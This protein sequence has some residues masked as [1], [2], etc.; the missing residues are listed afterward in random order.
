MSFPS[1]KESV[2]FESF[3]DTLRNL[4]I[5]VKKYVVADADSGVELSRNELC[6]A[7][8]D[9]IEV[10][11]DSSWWLGILE[12]STTFALSGKVGYFP[13]AVIEL[14]DKFNQ[15]E[16]KTESKLLPSNASERAII[17]A[18]SPLQVECTDLNKFLVH[19]NKAFTSQVSKS[20]FLRIDL[21]RFVCTQLGC[22]I[23]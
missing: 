1:F 13:A 4:E 7:Q 11:K 16:K 8:G 6:F 10:I 20:L 18:E 12:T 3:L 23:G 5:G 22:R 17:D 19:A 15:K 14:G 9:I 21:L 2:Q